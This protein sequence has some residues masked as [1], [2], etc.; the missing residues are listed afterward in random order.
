MAHRPRLP[1]D[2]RN[3]PR[4]RVKFHSSIGS[5]ATD[6]KKVQGEGFATD[7][8]TGG[9]KIESQTPVLVGNHLELQISVLDLGYPISIGGA[10]VRW[11]REREFGVEFITVSPGGQASLRQLIQRL[12]HRQV[13][14]RIIV[15]SCFV[16]QARPVVPTVC[17]G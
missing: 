13:K 10:V 16:C 2:R 6:P 3:A 5:I 7:L 8:S 4:Y 12:E 1:A 9:C 17:A 14:H 15:N 11:V